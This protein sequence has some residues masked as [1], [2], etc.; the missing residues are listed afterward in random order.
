[1]SEASR[2]AAFLLALQISPTQRERFRRDPK[3]E[4]I[5]FNLDPRTIEAVLRKDTK[6]L[7]RILAIPTTRVPIFIAKVVGVEKRDRRR[8]RR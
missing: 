7:W 8:K 5:Q 6:S 3:G 1:M 4:M 2:L